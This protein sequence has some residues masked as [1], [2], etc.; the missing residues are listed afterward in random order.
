MKIF[1]DPDQFSEPTSLA[2]GMFDGVHL[3]HR[4]VINSAVKLARA[5]GLIAAVLLFEPH[6]ARVLYPESPLKL[7]T[8][9]DEKLALLESLGVETAILLP[10][11][12]RIATLSPESF[13]R[14]ILLK[15]LGAKQLSVGFNY[16]FGKNKSGTSEMLQHQAARW[17]YGVEV[18]PP[19]LVDGVAVSSSL[20]RQ[21][22]GEQGDVSLAREFL[23]RDYRIRGE[24]VHGDKRGNQLGFPTANLQTNPLKLVPLSGVY[25]VRVTVDQEIYGG[26]AN[27]GYLPTFFKGEALPARIEVHLFGFDQPLYDKEIEVDFAQRIREERGFPSVEGLIYQIKTDIRMAKEILG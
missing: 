19:F 16:T 23:G 5:S 1:R 13:I 11:D 3:G 24:V 14:E 26:I 7:L 4:Q 15:R 8:L 21:L 12:S 22:V 27:I 10:F 20:I 18:L 9:T 25:A 17:G 6:P 2:L